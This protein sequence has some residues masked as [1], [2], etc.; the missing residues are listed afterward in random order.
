MM[1][2]ETQRGVTWLAAGAA[3]WLS[4]QTAAGGFTP[5]MLPAHIGGCRL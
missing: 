5:R 2:A 4:E 3:S 1:Q